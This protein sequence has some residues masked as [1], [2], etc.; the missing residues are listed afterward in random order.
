MAV[1]ALFKKNNSDFAILVG[2]TLQCTCVSEV[3]LCVIQFNS[4][5]LLWLQSSHHRGKNE[6]A[7]QRQKERQAQVKSLQFLC[8]MRYYYDK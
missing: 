6:V 4:I 1:S 5:I 2:L 7:K 8:L 3:F